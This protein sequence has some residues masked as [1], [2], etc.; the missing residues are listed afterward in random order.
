MLHRCSCLLKLCK[1][2]ASSKVLGQING[3]DFDARIVANCK[4]KSKLFWAYSNSKLKTNTKIPTIRD[5]QDNLSKVY[6]EKAVIL[7]IFYVVS[8]QL[9]T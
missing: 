7:N 2:N 5:D 8:S 6:Q 9:R 4:T 3:Y 1:Y